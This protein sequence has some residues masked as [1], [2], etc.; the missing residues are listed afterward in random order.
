MTNQQR[1]ELIRKVLRQVNDQGLHHLVNHHAIEAG[2]EEAARE[3]EEEEEVT[4][5]PRVHFRSEEVLEEIGI[6]TGK[7][8]LYET[9]L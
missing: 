1:L 5:D 2:N 6:T 3:T 9:I 7:I 4:P 8:L